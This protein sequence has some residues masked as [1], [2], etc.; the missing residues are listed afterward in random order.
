MVLTGATLHSRNEGIAP[1]TLPGDGGVGVY[2]GI[3]LNDGAHSL[4]ATPRNAAGASIGTPLTVT[5]TVV[6]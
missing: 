5:F 1:Y 4:T 3:T 2:F 6:P